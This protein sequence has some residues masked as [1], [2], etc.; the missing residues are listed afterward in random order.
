MLILFQG[1]IFVGQDMML[2]LCEQFNFT[3]LDIDSLNKKSKCD[4]ITYALEGREMKN[5]D[6]RAK[7]PVLLKNLHDNLQFLLLSGPRDWSNK[8]T[9]RFHLSIPKNLTGI[10]I[11]IYPNYA[12]AYSRYVLY[13][14]VS[15]T[16]PQSSVVE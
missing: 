3:T 14:G 12:E 11:V 1:I 8:D 4:P 2:H 5:E 15:I 9:A 6:L 10:W 13:D 16:F 7:M